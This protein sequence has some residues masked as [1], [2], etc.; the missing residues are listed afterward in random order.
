VQRRDIER[1][2]I[3]LYLA[4]IAWLLPSRFWLPACEGSARL[5]T[6]LMP[7]LARKW[8]RSEFPVGLVKLEMPRRKVVWLAKGR[9]WYSFVVLLGEHR[10]WGWRP[11]IEV[12][13][14]EHLDASLARG[15]GAIL[16][17]VQM[18]ASDLIVKRGLAEAGYGVVHLSRAG[19]GLG[20]R[21]PADSRAS[22]VLNRIQTSVE[23][24]YLLERV[25][26]QS[27]TTGALR[28]LRRHLA[29][30]H[31]VSITALRTASR[32]VS[33][34]FLGGEIIVAAGPAELAR[35]AR[36]NILPV[37]TRQAG[38]SSFEVLV[39]APLDLEDAG[40]DPAVGAARQLSG[41]LSPLVQE[42]PCQWLS[43]ARGLA[44]LPPETGP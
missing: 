33:V 19:H 21:G 4:P 26:M 27:S 10:P 41:L 14:R 12:H 34:P 11:R 36:C 32:V 23:C 13:G 15:S 18:G 43:W 20:P 1:I 5:I 40:E 2:A 3:L 28:A 6:W 29:Q 7:S 9:E 31:V 35:S 22:S 44:P 25:V 24:R 42:D 39:G 8:A 37:F 17:V 38:A 30:N 16:W